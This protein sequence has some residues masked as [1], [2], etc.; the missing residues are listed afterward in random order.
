MLWWMPEKSFSSIA[1]PILPGGVM[2][3]FQN[4]YGLLWITLS[5]FIEIQPNFYTKWA[6]YSIIDGANLAEFELFLS[7]LMS[8]AKKKNMKKLEWLLELRM[9]GTAGPIPFKFD[10]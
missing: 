6:L 2:K 9:L 5:I 8:V 7:G 1:L 4:F 10:M 3:N